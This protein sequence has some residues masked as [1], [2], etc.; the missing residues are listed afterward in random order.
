MSLPSFITGAPGWIWLVFVFLVYRG[1]VNLRPS[2][3]PIHSIFILPTIF[4][5]L[6]LFN[7]VN[8]FT[9]YTTIIWSIF[10]FIGMGIGWIIFNKVK[11][12][13]DKENGLIF[14][15]GS[16]FVLILALSTFILKYYFGYLAATQPELL[17]DSRLLYAKI[18][19]FALIGGIAW[20]RTSN[21]MM[22]FQNA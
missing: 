4:L 7:L 11:I 17:I 13:I 6:S 5:F 18:A 22:K 19:I 16:P 20:G 21:Y 8:N 12:K 2:I 10:F 15:P 3:V 14:N 1:I 9:F